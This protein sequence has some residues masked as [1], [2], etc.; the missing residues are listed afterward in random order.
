M[1]DE[2]QNLS[3]L[4]HIQWNDELVTYQ[5]RYF[6]LKTN[7][8]RDFYP[9]VMDYQ[10]KRAEL[11][12]TLN[13]SYKA[14]ELLEEEFNQGSLV[15]I[16]A[17]KFN[18]YYKGRIPIVPV[19]GRYYPRGMIEGVAGCFK[20]DNLPFRIV[21]KTP[22][23]LDI[24]L[25]HP[26]AAFPIQ[27]TATITDVFDANQQNGGRCNDIAELVTID[28]P[29]MQTLLA[30]HPSD[31]FQGM[32]FL[33]K[34]EDDD[35]VFYDS[36]ETRPSVDQVALEQLHQFYA[37]H[38]KNDMKI[39]DLMSGPD[40]HLPEDLEPLEVTGLG[41]KEQDLTDNSAL[42]Q[43][44][45]HDLNKVAELPF[46]DQQFD[47]VICSFSVEYMTQPITVFQEVA[48]IL[49]PG[50]IFLVSFSDR[51]YDKKVI[52]LW[53][54]LHLFERMGVVLEYF[55][56]SGEFE[57]LFAES[58]RGLIRHNDDPFIS[59]T[60]YSCPMFMLSGKQKAKKLK[61]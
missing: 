18:Q 8:W 1:I 28:G 21:N 5:D 15:T 53:D 35:A 37:D 19:I 36:V 9:P 59:N 60:V 42:N 26:L 47:A 48:R 50:G 45:I 16:P 44:V 4:V 33:R 6:I 27:L 14:G 12:Q 52:A 13:I 2:R 3:V 38:L 23:T 24:D 30:P 10:I 32:P 25:N 51:Y 61:G 54:D 43:Y 11:H 40:S 34:I 46:E 20:M 57:E 29:G 58:I 55:R 56:Q 49:K 41:L 17:S 31:F 39:L 7:F 22:E